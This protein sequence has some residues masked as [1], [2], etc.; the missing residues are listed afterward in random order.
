[1]GTIKWPPGYTE[2]NVAN[3][4]TDVTMGGASPSDTLYPSQKAVKTYIDKFALNPSPANLDYSGPTA[5]LTAGEALAIGNV[6]YQGPSGK[7]W[8]VKGTIPAIWVAATAY[9]IGSVVRRTNG[10]QDFWFFASANASDTKSG[11]SEPTWP[12]TIGTTVVDNNV[13]WTCISTQSYVARRMAT[14]TINANATGIF[15]IYGYIKNTAWTGYTPGSPLFVDASTAGSWTQT[16]PAASGNI[17]QIIGRVADAAN[18][19]FFMPDW[20]T[21]QVA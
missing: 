11:G 21:V 17:Q 2:E 3:K 12:T 6:C 16:A 19:L 7:W 15:L 5:V 10:V 8:K 14:G 13:T 1:M 4:S 18:T 20:G 9:A